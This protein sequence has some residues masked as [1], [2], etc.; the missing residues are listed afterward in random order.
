MKSLKVHIYPYHLTLNQSKTFPILG[1]LGLLLADDNN[2][3]SQNNNILGNISMLSS[4]SEV[5]LHFLV[6]GRLSW[7]FIH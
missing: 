6:L 1:R 4:N 3:F 2:L 5:F 7:V